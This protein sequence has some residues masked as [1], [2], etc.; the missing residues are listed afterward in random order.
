MPTLRKNYFSGRLSLVSFGSHSIA[1]PIFRLL[2]IIIANTLNN[3][4]NSSFTHWLTRIVTTGENV[5][6]AACN[7]AQLDKN[8]FVRLSRNH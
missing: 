4:I 2:R 1:V 7:L 3:L 8:G 6:P 5:F